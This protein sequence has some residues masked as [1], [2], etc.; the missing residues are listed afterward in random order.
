[1]PLINSQE[2]QAAML[3]AGSDFKDR[4]GIYIQ[5]TQNPAKNQFTIYL[6]KCMRRKTNR[7]H[8]Y[9][10]MHALFNTYTHTRM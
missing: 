2:A 9:T 8:M 7:T 1:M 4:M 3:G 5:F 6:V 10:H